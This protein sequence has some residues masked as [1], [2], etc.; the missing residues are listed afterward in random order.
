VALWC[1]ADKYGYEEC[2]HVAVKLSDVRGTTVAVA[3][4]L[5]F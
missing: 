5:T 1:L 3:G 4:G 2:A